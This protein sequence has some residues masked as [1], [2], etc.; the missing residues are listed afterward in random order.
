ML[1]RA[2]K[3]IA[4]SSNYIKGSPWLRQAKRKCVVI[5][6]CINAQRL[7]KS[8]SSK[9]IEKKIRKDNDGKIICLAVG[10]HTE[11]KGFRYL[12]Q[13]SKLLDDKFR[14]YI[15]GKGELT[16]ELEHEAYGDSKV[17]F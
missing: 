4:T 13:A 3:I 15:T 11:Y 2:D 12:I 14:I 6:N 5:P 17:K 10:R 1:E 9:K 16:E 7:E 8:A